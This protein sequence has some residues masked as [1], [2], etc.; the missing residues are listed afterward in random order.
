MDANKKG[1][2]AHWVSIL[3]VRSDMRWAEWLKSRLEGY[4][5]PVHL[6]GRPSADGLVPAKIGRVPILMADGEMTA[7]DLDSSRYLVILC[8]SD[9]ARSEEIDKWVKHFKSLE[10]EHRVQCLIVAG[11]PFASSRVEPDG[12]ECLPKAIKY[13]VNK[14]G[15]LTE[16]PA[17]PSAADLRAHRHGRR[18][19][20][21]KVLAGVLR[22]DY[23]EL[24]ERDFEQQQ[25][26][27]FQIMV[28][29]AALVVLLGLSSLFF[30]L[31]ARSARF[32]AE[33][34]DGRAAHLET[35]LEI[36]RLDLE[37]YKGSAAQ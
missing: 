18:S 3:C 5:V 20:F 19:S 23:E 36:L 7:T 30:M 8:S 15:D 26:K 34:A 17:S 10:R 29:A 16:T 33:A 32:E 22:L 14:N 35:E 25:K 28:V 9:A 2:F 13:E 24:K 27:S 6:E 31:Q 21:L 4:N 12:E 37:K 11:E 1:E